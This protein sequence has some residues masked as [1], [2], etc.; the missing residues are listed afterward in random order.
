MATATIKKEVEKLKERQAKLEQ[1]FYTI[2]EEE[3]EQEEEIKPKYIKKL[4]RIQKNIKNRKG[5]IL[6]H[7]KQEL[8]NFFGSL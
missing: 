7:N 4:E 2:F 5:V 1:A 8:K 6:I 3:I